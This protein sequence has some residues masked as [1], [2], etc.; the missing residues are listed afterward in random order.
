MFRKAL[1]ELLC[2]FAPKQI[3]LPVTLAFAK[4]KCFKLIEPYVWWYI[5]GSEYRR[6]YEGAMG[7]RARIYIAYDGCFDMGVNYQKTVA[8]G[9]FLTALFLQGVVHPYIKDQIV[10][11]HKE[12]FPLDYYL[13][14]FLNA[15]N[16]VVDHIKRK[17]HMY[18]IYSQLIVMGNM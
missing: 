13:F 4:A 7:N 8:R 6:V 12:E 16:S 3:N 2:R 14:K 5:K 15:K 10:V 9:G 17:W 11:D 1:Y 18:V